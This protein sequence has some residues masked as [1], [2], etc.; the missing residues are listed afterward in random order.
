MKLSRIVLSRLM[1][2]QEEISLSIQESK[3]G[4]GDEWVVDREGDNSMLAVHSLI[5]QR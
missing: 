2:E 3:I 5:R 1:A 4:L